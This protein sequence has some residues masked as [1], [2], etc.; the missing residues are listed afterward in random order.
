MG[1]EEASADTSCVPLSHRNSGVRRVIMHFAGF[2]VHHCH[3]SSL[4]ASAHGLGWETSE[5]HFQDKG[6]LLFRT[7][8]PG[9][10]CISPQ[11]ACQ[12]VG[13]QPSHDVS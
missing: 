8:N 2:R 1:H 4:N 13:G 6:R 11:A 5:A 3:S 7:Q 9:F 10:A 12:A